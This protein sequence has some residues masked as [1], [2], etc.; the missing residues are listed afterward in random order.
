MCQNRGINQTQTEAPTRKGTKIN[1]KKKGCSNKQSRQSFLF[2]WSE[3]LVHPEQQIS[4]VGA[5]QESL[6][7]SLFAAQTDGDAVGFFF[8]QMC[9][10]KISS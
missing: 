4:A 7:P 8:P 10:D 2:G 9:E 3:A 1:T 6:G 5:Q